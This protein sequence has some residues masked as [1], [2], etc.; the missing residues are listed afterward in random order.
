M[1]SA[2]PAVEMRLSSYSMAFSSR[3]DVLSAAN[4]AD[5]H[6]QRIVKLI[7]HPLLQRNDGIVGDVDIFRADLG[8]A[9]R[10]VTEANAQFFLQQ[11]RTGGAVERMHLKRSS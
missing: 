7:H 8:A 2:I 3:L 10:D 5:K 4:L 6:E 9:L 11:M 1:A